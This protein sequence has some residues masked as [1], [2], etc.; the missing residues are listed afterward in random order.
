MKKLFLTLLLLT[1]SFHSYSGSCTLPAPAVTVTSTTAC[2]V[3]LS[4]HKIAGVDHFDVKY[5]VSGTNDWLDTINVANDTFAIIPGLVAQKKYIIRVTSFCGLQ[6]PGGST[7][8]NVKT[9]KCTPP[10]L[11]TLNVNGD[12]TVYISWDG[13][14]S[15]SN[16][17]RYRIA[18]N[19][20]WTT[21]NTNS[22][23]S[24]TLTG[25]T[26]GTLYEF[27]MKSCS[28]SLAQYWSPIDS[29]ILVISIPDTFKKPNI[30]VLL[31]DDG[32]FN[33]YIPNGGPSYFTSPSVNRIASEGANFN[34][35]FVALS[36]CNPSRATLLTGLMP[37]HHGVLSNSDELAASL[38]TIGSI[39]QSSGYYTA[40]VGKFPDISS[41]SPRAGWNYWMVSQAGSGLHQNGNYNV[42]GVSKEIAG[43]ND[44]TLTDT[45]IRLIKSNAHK[46]PY[47]IVLA[48]SGVHEPFLAPPGM[49]GRY[50]TAP[51]T[52][53]ENFH[54]YPANYPAQIYDGTEFHDTASVLLSIRNDFEMLNGIDTCMQRM[55]ATMDSLHETDSTMIVYTSDNGYL[56]GEHLLGGKSLPYDPSMR[57]P[58]FIRY[59]KWFS[60]ASE[61]NSPL[62]VNIDLAPTIL[63]AA[64]IPDTYNMDGFSLHDYYTGARDRDQFYFESSTIS[65]VRSVR[66]KTYKY[67][68]Y[69]CTSPTEEFFNLATDPNED[70]NHI[71]TAAYSALIAE[72]RYKLDSL[73]SY[74]GDQANIT[75]RPCYLVNPVYNRQ[76]ED[77]QNLL[78]LYPDPVN[79]VLQIYWAGGAK[80]SSH[81]MIFNTSGT[82]E[83]ETFVSEDV[84]EHSLNVPVKSFANGLYEVVIDPGNE[85]LRKKFMVMK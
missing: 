75:P 66:S 62:T 31:V 52:V 5:K 45:T 8:V 13:C 4:W 42:N 2:G 12:S 19:A 20:V 6:K 41:S 44:Y 30:L 21:K 84:P 47:L 58:L 79:D 24:V 54:Y 59:P 22:T 69:Y 55:L 16:S 39:L 71:N 35:F 53:P 14:P 18:G 23:P 72:Y 78:L 40:Y 51:V 28:S 34:N 33:C 10:F 57:V 15:T 74:W 3:G 81:V 70:T 38:P 36:V 61:V 1:L 43:F 56:R 85:I 7:T 60:P 26:Y 63:D 49:N 11:N 67:N 46:K 68:K 37:N 80:N 25:L 27:Q 65:N 83:F 73:K 9:S 82:L 48:F 77:V 29:F 76:S 50:D 17:L 64:G 32:S